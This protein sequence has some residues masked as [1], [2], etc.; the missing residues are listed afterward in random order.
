MTTQTG[1]GSIPRVW[2]DARPKARGGNRIVALVLALV[3]GAVAALEALISPV[4][5]IANLPL[6]ASP[7]E[8]WTK[9]DLSP[10]IEFEPPAVGGAPWR[11]E[12]DIERASGAR[13]DTYR[14]GDFNGDKP[15]AYIE[16]WTAREPSGTSL[17]VALA[18]K[19]SL[20]G[21][22]IS[23]FGA[24][25]IMATSRGGVEFAS[26]VLKGP[27]GNRACSGFRF[28]SPTAGGLGG[29]VCPGRS[30]PSSENE[31]S[32]LISELTPTRAGPDAGLADVVKGA[33]PRHGVCRDGLR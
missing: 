3:V 8:T 11:G 7:A 5:Q 13:R 29:F 31:L 27:T 25:Q 24:V 12:V 15:S 20:F 26:L 21:A 28:A 9:A 33:P 17:F 32:C 10:M 1:F 18:E 4:P 30:E 19:A 6:A 2:D 23:R 14:L 22:S 16:A